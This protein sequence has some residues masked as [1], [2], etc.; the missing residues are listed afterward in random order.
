MQ[1]SYSLDPTVAKEGMIADSRSLRH[2]V[3]RL[4]EGVVKAGLAVFRVPV[5]GSP[6][7]GKSGDPGQVYQAPSPAAAVDVDAIVTAFTT[8][9]DI[10]VLS[11]ALLDGAV[12]GGSMRPGRLI[13][14]TLSSHADWNATTMVVTGELGGVAKSENVAIPDG[15]NATIST[16]GAFD[17]VT[18]ITIPAQASTGGTATFGIAVLDGTVNEADFEGFAIYDGSFPSDAIPSQNQTAEY[19]DR[20]VVNVMQLGSF[21]AVAEVPASA[22]YKGAVYVRISGGQMGAVRHDADG[23]AAIAVTGWRFACDA[24]TTN[25]LVK[26]ERV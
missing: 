12:G 24:N 15:G 23:G 22:L 10:Q 19:H 4:C 1:T 9:A 8:S 14:A 16:V 25:G 7:T 5:Y 18:S 13:T 26:V 17:K 20:Q 11:G 3:S 2:I 6:F 21:W